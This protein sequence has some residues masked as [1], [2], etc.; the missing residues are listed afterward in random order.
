MWRLFLCKASSKN[1]LNSLPFAMICDSQFLGWSTKF[2]S[3]LNL[4]TTTYIKKPDR[5]KNTRICNEEVIESTQPFQNWGRSDAEFISLWKKNNGI[6]SFKMG[7]KVKCKKKN[8]F[9]PETVLVYLRSGKSDETFLRKFLRAFRNEV[10]P[11]LKF[12]SLCF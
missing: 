10:F 11:N 8:N 7:F 3:N 1:L 12:F 6:K 9:F 5:S 4:I 2:Q